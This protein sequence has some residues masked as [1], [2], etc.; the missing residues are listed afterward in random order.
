[1][2]VTK[3]PRKVALD[4]CPSVRENP[5][6]CKLLAPGGC[7]PG[8]PLGLPSPVGCG[9]EK[10]PYG[11]RLDQTRLWSEQ[12]I[13]ESRR[14]FLFYGLPPFDSLPGCLFGWVGF[15]KLLSAFASVPRGPALPRGPPPRFR[16]SGRLAFPTVR[17]CCV[18]GMGRSVREGGAPSC[19]GRRPPPPAGWR[20]SWM[21]FDQSRHAGPAG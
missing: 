2:T 14:P 9:A 10:G 12:G 3:T 20:S 16:K 1:M 11:P 21:I 4:I 17:T 15:S 7:S 18:L 8:G 5:A 13:I 6:L 19:H